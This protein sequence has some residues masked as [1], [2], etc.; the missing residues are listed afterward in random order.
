MISKIKLGLRTK[1]QITAEKKVKR[2]KLKDKEQ[3]EA[4]KMAT[5]REVEGKALEEWK[6]WADA[7]RSDLKSPRDIIGK[8]KAMIDTWW[9][10][11]E[12]QVV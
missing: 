1:R 8:R 12:I 4:F 9:W 10:S 5:L 6:K 7:M 11:E 2:W 3:K